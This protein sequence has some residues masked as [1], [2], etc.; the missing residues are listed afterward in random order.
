MYLQDRLAAITPDAANGD[1][2][3]L[4]FQ[5]QSNGQTVTLPNETIAAGTIVVYMLSAPSAELG[6]KVGTA[7]QPT[8]NVTGSPAWCDTVYGRGQAGALAAPATDVSPAAIVITVAGGPAQL[9]VPDPSF[10]DE[11]TVFGTAA[12]A[13]LPFVAVG[14]GR[15]TDLDAAAQILNNQAVV[16]GNFFGGDISSRGGIRVAANDLN[17]DGTNDLIVGAG[18]KSGSK[19]TTYDGSLIRA[20]STPPALFALDAPPNFTGDVFVG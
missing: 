6:G 11:N 5:N 17:A 15:L 7:G 4:E 9:T 3:S 2:W 10:W 20:G 14:G 16:I 8:Y 1:T 12:P 19:V 13:M 18:E